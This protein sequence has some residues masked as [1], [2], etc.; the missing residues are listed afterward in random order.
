MNEFGN[1][2]RS[3][4]EVE[5]TEVGRARQL[6]GRAMVASL[7]LEATA[8]ACLLLWSLTQTAVLP[9]EHR[10]APTPV[11]P[12]TP[13]AN[14]LPARKPDRPAPSSRAILSG[15]RLPQPRRIPSRVEASSNNEPPEINWVSPTEGGLGPA[16]GGA[17]ARADLVAQQPKTRRLALVLS[18]GVIEARRIHYVQPRYPLTAKLIH[19]TGT[20]QLR[21]IIGTDGLV[22]NLQVVSG[23]PILAKA[24][25]DA[26]RQWRYQPTRL[27][28]EP[29]EVETV[30]TVEFH[31]Q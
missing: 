11:F 12:S 2:G 7:S 28:G 30:I 21:A 23:N 8:I 9:E 19:L 24:A 20:V 27:S 14:P 10:P 22:Q 5:V 29:V 26:V 13:R 17:G 25:I 3:I 15:P 1:V 18:G 4:L 6:R 31:M 16:I